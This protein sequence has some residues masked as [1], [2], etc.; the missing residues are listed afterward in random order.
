V[1]PGRWGDSIPRVPPPAGLYLNVGC[2]EFPAAG[3]LNID[4]THPCADLRHD[5]TTGLPPVDGPVGRIYAGHL[6]EHLPLADL[7]RVL[8]A[9]RRHPGVTLATRLAVVGPDCDTADYLLREHRIS[10]DTHQGAVDG[11]GRWAGDVHLWRSTE[12][13]TT[14]LLLDAGWDTAPTTVHQLRDDGWPVIS[15][16]DWQF[17]VLATPREPA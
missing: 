9:W 6:L 4:C 1:T 14:R 13:V 2:G 16:V 8:A 11:A 15:L 17:A 7:P 10:L 5:I 12:D 3:W